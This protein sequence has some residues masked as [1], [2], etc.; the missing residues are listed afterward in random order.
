MCGRVH[1]R[2]NLKLRA[3]PEKLMSIVMRL[4]PA[5]I[6]AKPLPRAAQIITL[7]SIFATVP[8]ATANLLAPTELDGRFPGGLQGRASYSYTDDQNALTTQS[9]TN[10]PH[11]LAKLNVIAPMLQQK[12]FAGLE[13]QFNSRATTLEGGTASS[14]QVFNATLL[15]HA[16]GKHLDVS[17]SA[18][19]LLDKKYFDPAPVGLTQD[20]IQQNGRNFRAQITARF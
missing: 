1:A 19:N 2:H 6:A 7:L 3:P 13:A 17:A 11:H 12:L 18:Y 9:L 20:Q 16:M 4:I 15:G 8:L 10:S 5:S 14:F